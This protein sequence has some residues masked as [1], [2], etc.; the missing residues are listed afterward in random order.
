MKNA[1]ICDEMPQKSQNFVISS[2]KSAVFRVYYLLA[3]NGNGEQDV[4]QAQNRRL[5]HGMALGRG[6]ASADR[7]WSA[8]GRQDRGD[9]PL[10][11]LLL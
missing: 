6:P 5:S 8:A 3:I 2:L 9:P 11:R 7:S 4:F 10:R 1:E